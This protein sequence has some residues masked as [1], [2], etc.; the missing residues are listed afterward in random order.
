VANPSAKTDKTQARMG[1]PW[2]SLG[3][4][5]DVRLL[6]VHVLDAQGEITGNRIEPD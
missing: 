4:H 3:P 5:R 6:S 1:S 2:I